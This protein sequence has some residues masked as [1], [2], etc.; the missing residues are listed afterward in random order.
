LNTPIDTLD[1][2]GKP[3]PI[4]NNNIISAS[5]STVMWVW[6][7]CAAIGVRLDN[8]SCEVLEALLSRMQMNTLDL[9]RTN[10]ED[11]VRGGGAS[12]AGGSGGRLQRKFKISELM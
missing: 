7:Q 2:K 12:L 1:L 3:K 10:L 6:S 11:E 8:K 4:K 9:Q 5:V